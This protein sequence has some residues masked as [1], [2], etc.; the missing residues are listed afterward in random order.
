MHSQGASNI[1]Y[2]TVVFNF[3]VC[4][5]SLPV[6]STNYVEITGVS[7]SSLRQTANVNLYHVT[8][9]SPLF[10]KFTGN[11]NIFTEIVPQVGEMQDSLSVLDPHSGFRIPGNGF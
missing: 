2:S 11:Y 10:L 7:E 6:S 3:D 4:W 9:V 8:K 5:L 1:N